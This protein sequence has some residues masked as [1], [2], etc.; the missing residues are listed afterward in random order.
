MADT[1]IVWI[2]QKEKG[3]LRAIFKSGYEKFV[4]WWL[5][6]IMTEKGYD[7]LFRQLCNLQIEAPCHNGTCIGYMDCNYGI[8]GCYGEECA[9]DVVREEANRKYMEMF[10]EK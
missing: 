6:M 2:V 10:K 5:N 1:I 8:N 9:I 3:L 7:E 4:L